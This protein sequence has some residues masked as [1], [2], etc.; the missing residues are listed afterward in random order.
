MTPAWVIPVLNLWACFVGTVGFCIAYSRR[1]PN[2]DA[3]AN[4]ANSFF[5]FMQC[6]MWGA[7]IFY[8]VS[9]FFRLAGHPWVSQR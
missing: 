8:I 7:E 3:V 6:A 5:I 9:I 2:K 1:N 4:F